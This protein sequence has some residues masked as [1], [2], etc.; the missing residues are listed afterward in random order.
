MRKEQITVKGQLA[1]AFSSTAIYKIYEVH[2][3]PSLNSPGT[4]ER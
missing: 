1:N 4:A 3:A 2:V